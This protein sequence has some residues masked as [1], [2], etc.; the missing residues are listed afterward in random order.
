[1]ASHGYSP[2]KGGRVKGDHQAIYKKDNVILV[3]KN[4]YR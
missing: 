2:Y 3:K 4:T 1:M